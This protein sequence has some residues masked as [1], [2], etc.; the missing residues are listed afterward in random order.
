[1]TREQ[2]LVRTFVE[3]ADTLTDEFDAIELMHTLADR[4]VELLDVGAAGIVLADHAGQLAVVASSCAETRLLKLF[5]LQNSE[6]PCFECFN[7][8]RPV[9]NVAPAEAEQRWPRFSV[10]SAEAGY[11]S[12]HALPMR[13]RGKVVGAMNLFCADSTTLSEANLSVGQAMADVATIALLQEQAVS[14]HEV[15]VEQLQTALNSR[16]IIEQAK[17]MLAERLHTD[18]DSAFQV[19]RSQARRQGRRLGVVAGE[20]VDGTIEISQLESAH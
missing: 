5:E 13:L 11:R 16:V 19:M 8:G 1:M 14:H 4:C 9:A 18:V 15:L 2:H 10:V 7:T 20:V 3:L 17:G 12:A 6:G